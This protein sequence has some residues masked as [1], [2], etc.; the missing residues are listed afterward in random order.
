[1]VKRLLVCLLP[2]LKFMAPT[3]IVGGVIGIYPGYKAYEYTW[4]ESGFC[5]QC[6][7]HDYANVSWKKSIHGAVTTCHD[8]HHQ[9]LVQYFQEAAA[10]VLDKPQFPSDMRHVPHIDKHLCE[11]CHWDFGTKGRP[12]VAG[13]LSAHDLMDLPKVS[14]THL[15]KLH[16]AKKVKLPLPKGQSLSLQKGVDLVKNTMIDHTPGHQQTGEWPERAVT[17]VDC[18]GGIANRAHNFGATDIA[19]VRCHNA[20]DNRFSPTHVQSKHGCRGCHFM[21]FMV[22]TGNAPIP[23]GDGHSSH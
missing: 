18:H 14:N 5:T 6:H 7:I 22:E 1:M 2:L 20:K 9:P 16:L 19:C 3:L 10:L 12:D 21:E 15:H 17:C 13:P 4:V 11:T 23:P 8:C